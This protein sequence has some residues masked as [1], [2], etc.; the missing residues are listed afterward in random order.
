MRRILLV[1]LLALCTACA[2]DHGKPIASLSYVNI[3]AKPN[4]DLY[5][6]DFSSDVDLLNLFH[7]NESLIGG[8]LVCALSD[9]EDFSVE[10]V[11]K[12]SASGQIEPATPALVDDR[13]AFVATMLFTE[14]L[15]NGTSDRILSANEISTLISERQQI[16]CRYIMTAYNVEPYYSGVLLLPTKDILRE[17]A[18]QN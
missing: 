13:F 5:S 6:I 2:K 12:Q 10:H 9:D 8:R 17:I 1:A 3:S 15:D 18:R 14:T 7:A 4:E 11:L 16:P